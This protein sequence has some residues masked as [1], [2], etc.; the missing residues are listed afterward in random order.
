MTAGQIDQ[1][2][3]IAQHRVAPVIAIESAAHALSLGCTTLTF[4][5]AKAAGKGAPC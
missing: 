3:V 1:L 4:F 5:P 2:A